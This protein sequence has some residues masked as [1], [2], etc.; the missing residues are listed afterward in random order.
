MEISEKARFLKDII[1]QK[2]KLQ[3]KAKQ[4]EEQINVVTAMENKVAHDI[5]GLLGIRHRCYFNQ[6]FY[7][8]KELQRQCS[9]LNPKRN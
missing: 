4:I 2:E 9:E 3:Q 1:S 8:V 6:A 5:I 7:N